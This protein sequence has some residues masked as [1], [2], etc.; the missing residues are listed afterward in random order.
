MEGP[1]MSARF[2]TAYLVSIAMAAGIISQA[3]AKPPDLPAK[4]QIKCEKS[5]DKLVLKTYQVGDLVI[6]VE[7]LPEGLPW[8]AE[9]ALPVHPVM[10][11]PPVQLG[12][13]PPPVPASPILA[14]PPAQAAQYVPQPIYSAPQPLD[15]V[16]L[17][18]PPPMV[19][20]PV[21]GMPAVYQVIKA[22]KDC[23]PACQSGKCVDCPA[24]CTGPAGV[25]VGSKTA[26][27]KAPQKTLE[28]RLIR[29]IVS[30]I[31]PESWDVNGGRGTIDYFPLGMV[32]TV[33]QSPEVHEKVAELLA[34]LQH[35]QDEQIAVEVRVISVPQGFGEKVACKIASCAEKCG[36]CCKDVAV[37]AKETKS[38]S[39]LLGAGVNSDCG[40]CGS[41]CEE[42]S[43]CSGCC[44][45]NAAA[46]KDQTKRTYLSD[47]QV[48]KLMDC[49][50]AN[51]K[52]NVMMAPKVTVLNGQPANVIVNDQHFFVTSVKF[53]SQG[54]QP[55]FFPENNP[56]ETGFRFSVKPTISKDYRFVQ[57]SLEVE[58][59][60][61]DM[62]ADH[63]PLFPVTSFITPV[64]EGGAKGEPV[65]FTMFLQQP[66]FV[67]QRVHHEVCVPCGRTFLFKGWTRCTE[68][69]EHSE[70]PVLSNLP[71]VGDMFKNVSYHQETADVWILVTP[72]LILSQEQEKV[73][74]PVAEALSVTDNLEKLT[75]ARALLKQAEYYTRVGQPAAA[76]YFYE[77]VRQLC[78]GSRYAQLAGRHPTYSRA[79]DDKPEEVLTMTR[80]TNPETK[81]N[82][83]VSRYLENYWKACEEGR[84]SEATQWAIQALALDP[85][86]FNKAREAKW[87]R[88]PTYY[89][90]A[91]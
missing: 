35:L 88:V 47:A 22:P 85:T 20:V 19:S 11:I 38:G 10:A 21:P 32:I 25:A 14:L 26:P 18:V 69:P 55:I 91:N 83:K 37:T 81:T 17:P 68:I 60:T 23:C 41:V 39:V 63:V 62:A 16:T 49:L 52:T 46:C 78:P 56:F 27:A 48:K 61:L 9:V 7:G 64:F 76:Q 8:A 43:S 2:T 30:T 72:R 65:P 24:C 89:P 31:N 80:V 42:G 5:S 67:T 71:Y 6:P 70:I 40:L 4:V 74:P 13:I 79:P 28:D 45:K 29:L 57:M 36:S 50:Q 82:L 84:M 59:K 90:S 87:Q 44:A 66:S 12:I 77:R 54:D 15:V 34:Y 1:F 75:Q 58:E 3:L 73:S 33:N 53:A 51:P 86:C